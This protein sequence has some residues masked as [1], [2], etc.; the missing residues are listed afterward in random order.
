LVQKN[1]DGIFKA[2][3]TELGLRCNFTLSIVNRLI[4]HKKIELKEFERALYVYNKLIYN[5]TK[6][7]FIPGE[8]DYA[9]KRISLIQSS[10]SIHKSQERLISRLDLIVAQLNKRIEFEVPEIIKSEAL[11]IVL[12]KIDK[13]EGKSGLK[14]TNI[15]GA[16]LLLAFRKI[17][18]PIPLDFVGEAGV[19]SELILKNKKE[20][21]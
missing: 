12:G 14:H 20:V 19:N 7:Y 8:D 5:K 9:L 13:T 1:N 6:I 11:K 10:S 21:I 4:F 18:I 2:I 16:S 15:S 3:Y 17:Q